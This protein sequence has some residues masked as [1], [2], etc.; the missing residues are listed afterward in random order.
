ML[1]SFNFTW[2]MWFLTLIFFLFLVIHLELC[3]Y[4]FFVTWFSSSP[5]HLICIWEMINKISISCKYDNCVFPLP[6][7]DYEEDWF[8]K[9]VKQFVV[10]HHAECLAILSRSLELPSEVGEVSNITRLFYLFHFKD[11]V[12]LIILNGAYLSW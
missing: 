5:D 3:F 6:I 7:I 1:T 2:A 8:Q 11:H 4:I 12:S 10:I 9:E